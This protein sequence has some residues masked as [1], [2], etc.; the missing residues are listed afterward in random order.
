MAM[1]VWVKPSLVLAVALLAS[2]CSSHPDIH[3]AEASGDGTTLHFD[4][5]ACHGDYAVTVSEDTEQVRV[6]ITDQRGRSPFSG[7]DDCADQVG[8][9]RLEAPLGDRLLIDAFHN[10]EIPVVYT[11]WN[12]GK[13]SDAD[14][15]AAVEA[16]ARC[17]EELDSEAV[18]SIVTHPDGYPDLRV[19][20]PDL[21]DG[22]SRSGNPE[23]AC[24]EQHIDPLRR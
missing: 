10:V 23:G 16:A 24:V 7:G 20:L 21:G 9:V 15:L 4:M 12:Q 19:V 17:V 11:P 13:H 5:N 6:S 22:E 8:P 14:Y 3:Y 1:R 2:S 18:V